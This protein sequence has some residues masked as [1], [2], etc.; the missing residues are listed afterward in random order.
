M[1]SNSSKVLMAHISFE[2]C[3]ID[4]RFRKNEKLSNSTKILFA[5]FIFLESL[6]SLYPQPKI[7]N[8]IF[9][10]AVVLS[11]FINYVNSIAPFHVEK[12]K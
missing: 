1:L 6:K 3:N 9:P 2:F 10:S 8:L 7:R 5:I 12:G 11:V 4:F